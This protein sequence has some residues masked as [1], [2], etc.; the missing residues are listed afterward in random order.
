MM[1]KTILLAVLGLAMAAPTFAQESVVKQVERM[2]K[3]DG[4]NLDEARNLIAPALTH[5]ETANS[6]Y[7][8]YVAGLIEEKAV[9]AGYMNLSLGKEID[10]PKFYKAVEAMTDYYMK[11]DSLDAL[12]NEKGKVKRKYDDKIQKGL[13]TYYQFLVNGG[14][15]AMD[16]K[17]F[18]GA[19]RMFKK[20]MDVKKMPLFAGTPVAETD[21][22]SMQIGFFSAY[23]ASQMTDNAQ[24]AIAEYESIKS[25]PFRQ[26]DVYQ[27]LSQSYLN[28]GDTAKYISTLEEGSKL[29]PQENF[30]LFNMINMYIQKGQH[31]QAKGF[32]DKA[33][34]ENPQDKQLYFV[35]AT[36]YEQGFKDTAKAEEAFQKALSIDPEYGDA[37]IGLGRIYYNQA[38]NIQSEANAITGNQAAYEKANANA[39]TL[40]KKA[41]PFFEKA[42]KI[43]PDNMQYLIA[44]RG[45]YYN[46]KMDDK[47]NEMEKLIQSKQ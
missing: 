41:L 28:A 18:T 7:A 29:F 31:E 43:E 37:V 32:L 24:G 34:A 5:P 36:V 20:F 39:Q 16:S 11:A 27:L 42:V 6:A 22:M 21:S 47:Y 8:W 14:G 46:L 26:N 15:V 33:I 30:Y 17:D 4:A 40:F 45:I 25:V 19:H 10:E 9:D 1:K 12:P 13:Q 23:A 2:A 35:L 38:A 3:K 44:L